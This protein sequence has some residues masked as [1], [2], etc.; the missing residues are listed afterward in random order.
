MMAKG[1][2]HRTF[3]LNTTTTNTAIGRLAYVHPTAGKLFYLQIWL[4]HQK[5]CKSFDNVRT[6]RGTTHNTFWETCEALGLTS[7]DRVWL[8]AFNEASN[9]AMSPELCSLF[10]HLLLFCEVGNLPLLWEAAKSKMSD[11]ITYAYTYNA[12]TSNVIIYSTTIE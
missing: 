8:T 3:T 9:W 6:I 12:S 5:G 1:W 10:C 7:N 4:Y 2:I 11:S